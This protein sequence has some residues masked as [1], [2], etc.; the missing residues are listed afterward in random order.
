MIGEASINLKQLLED[1]S[2]VKKPLGLNKSYYNDVLKP[3]NF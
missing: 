1:C 2:L 3:N